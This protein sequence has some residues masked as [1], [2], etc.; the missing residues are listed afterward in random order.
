MGFSNG[1]V[2]PCLWVLSPDLLSES[3][4]FLPLKCGYL[5]Y[6]L[7]T[8]KFL[9]A[10]EFFVCFLLRDALNVSIVVSGTNSCI[11]LFAHLQVTET[12]YKS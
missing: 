2:A 5:C 9:I 3:H 6:L 8:L 4:Y 12:P 7:T 10:V 11:R 1:T